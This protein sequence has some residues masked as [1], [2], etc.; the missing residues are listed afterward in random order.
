MKWGSVTR[1]GWMVGWMGM[2]GAEPRP[3]GEFAASFSPLG[4]KR[5]LSLSPQLAS[6]LCS[7][8]RVAELCAFFLCCFS[9]VFSLAWDLSVLTLLGISSPPMPYD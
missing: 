8:S 1:N 2:S 5:C 6:S 4:P 7:S 9:E 3:P